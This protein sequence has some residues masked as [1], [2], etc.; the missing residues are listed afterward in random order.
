MALGVEELRTR[1]A[2]LTRHPR[3]RRIVIWSV[4]VVLAF[5]VLLGLAAPPL[6]RRQLAAALTEKL[7]REVSIEQIRINPYAMTLAVRGFLM[8]ER[9]GQ[10]PQHQRRDAGRPHPDGRGGEPRQ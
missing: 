1:A 9:Q 8:K 4:A 7:H 5:G 2:E 6:I 10:A 3:T